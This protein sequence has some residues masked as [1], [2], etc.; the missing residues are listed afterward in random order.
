LNK[1]LTA[2]DNHRSSVTW[3]VVI[4]L[5]ILRIPYSITIIYFL[6]IENQNGAAIYEVGTY[7]LIAFL[8]WWEQD[9]LLKFHIDTPALLMILLLRPAQ[10]LILAHWHVDAP[11]AFPSL[12]SLIIWTI[13]II[14]IISLWR[15]GYKI[16]GFTRSTA[17]WLIFG[18]LLGICIS[19]AENVSVFRS[20]L[21]N[22][23]SFPPSVLASGSINILY[24]LGFAPI[25]E[26]PLF[27]GFLWGMLRQLKLSDGWIL[28]IQTLLFSSAHVYFANQYPLMFWVYIPIAAITFGLLT[29]HSRSIGPAIL[30]HGLI[31]GS[32]YVV[33]AGIVS[34]MHR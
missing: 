9:D 28:V 14:L 22:T 16:T 26:E 19:I 24:H 30:T 2:P 29:L 17:G 8:I 18:V 1:M 11:M 10:T 23:D 33:V 25:N 15:S 20:M 31:N 7:L 21:S 4:L 12:P 27:R 3:C 13:S 5:L 32:A 6:P 34:F